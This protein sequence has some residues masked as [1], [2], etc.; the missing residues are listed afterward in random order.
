MDLASRMQEP[1]A[2]DLLYFQKGKLITR[3]NH[4]SNSNELY[5][6]ILEQKFLQ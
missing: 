6:K 2:N 1:S 5:A 4:L 3:E